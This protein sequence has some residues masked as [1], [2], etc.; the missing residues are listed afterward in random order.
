ME[1]RRE[2]WLNLTKEEAIEPYL[3]ICDPHHHLWDTPDSVPESQIPVSHRHIHHYL[4][5]ELLRDIG[6]AHNIVKTIFIECRSMYRKEGPPEFRPLGETEFVQGIAAQMASGQYGNTEVASGI[7]G[8]ADLMLG[9]AVAPVLEAHIA[10]SRRRFRGVRYITTW[11]ASKE[12]ESRAKGPGLLLDSKFREGFACLNRYGL[13]FDSFL[14]PSQLSDLVG[15]ARAFPDT[16]IILNHIARPLGIG[17]YAGKRQEIF[18][19]WKK[20]MA[21]LATCHNVV[22]KLGGFG[23]TTSGFGWHEQP[24]SPNSSDLT[25]AMTPYFDW[26]IEKFGTNRCMFESNFPV[27]RISY[28]YNV[29]WNA[30]KR[31]SKNFSSVERSQLF[32]DTA[33]KIY[34][35]SP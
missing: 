29:V 27:D 5:N 28:S 35:L 12:I 1:L 33:V 22:V 30:F 25:R 14:Y 15:L 10:A 24:I 13:S 31:Y 20:G 21:D 4:L 32:H 9:S 3:P 17:P 19:V 7:V 34:R 2:K 23:N 8:F 6:G 18:E 11:D 16:P 26:C